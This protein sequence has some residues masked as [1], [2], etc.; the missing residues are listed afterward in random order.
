MTGNYGIL[1]PNINEILEPLGVEKLIGSNPGMAMLPGLMNRRDSTIQQVMQMIQA[2]NKTRAGFAQQKLNDE[3]AKAEME[4]AAALM[5]NVA[6]IG[7]AGYDLNELTPYM[8]WLRR[9]NQASAV[10]GEHRSATRMY[11]EAQE[12][13]A[14]HKDV[15]AGFVPGLGLGTKAPRFY[16]PANNPANVG[17][18]ITSD[19]ND[20]KIVETLG[21]DNQ[22]IARQ[23]TVRGGEQGN[24]PAPGVATPESAVAPQ[25]EQAIRNANPKL[26]TATIARLPQGKGFT[27]TYKSEG[28]DVIVH[29]PADPNGRPRPDQMKRIQ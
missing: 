7:K 3:A 16:N 24:M 27:A 12:A 17:R 18:R 8:P 13:E 25:A 6:N 20:G 19:A 21:P 5:G 23:R 10:A 15:D 1:D 2:N 28:K 4:H 26:K 9:G 29:I 11:T 14:R 22:V